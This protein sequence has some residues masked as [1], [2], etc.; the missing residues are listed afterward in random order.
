LLWLNFIEP[1]F[2]Q[3]KVE[4]K[5]QKF[6][7]FIDNFKWFYSK[8]F[9]PYT[10]NIN[11]KI[12]VYSSSNYLNVLKTIY[13]WKDLENKNILS[14]KEEAQS[15]LLPLSLFVNKLI[16]AWLDINKI[17]IILIML[18]WTIV[19]SFLRQII[20]LSVFWLYTPL[21]FSVLLIVFWYELVLFLLF[22]SI[23]ATLSTYF[24]SK[25]VYILY[26]SR[27]SL[28]YAIYIIYFIFILWII[29]SIWLVENI[30]YKTE[31]IILFFIM[32][33]L[34]KN[35]VRDNQK[36]FSLWFIL[37]L[38]EFLFIS[39]LLLWIYQISIIKYLIIAYPDILWLFVLLIIIIW[40]FTGLQ[41]LEYIRFYPLIKKKIYE[42]E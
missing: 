2:S 12:Y 16:W 32:P 21:L 19:I 5:N 31:A 23:L 7:F 36:V 11:S 24:L 38:V 26:S 33:L 30:N 13:L 39:F 1:F 40:K 4:L 27:I 22:I 29:I 10:K 34:T 42:E 28:N 9:I 6:V 18:L 8:L 37:M 20:W 25:K 3:N 41:L 14:S 35:L 17:W 15:Y